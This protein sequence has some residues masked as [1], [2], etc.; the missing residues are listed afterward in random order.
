MIPPR[1]RFTPPP[2]KAVWNAYKEIWGVDF[3]TVFDVKGTQ[4]FVFNVINCVTREL[5]LSNVTT[6]PDLRWVLQQIRNCAMVT[7]GQLPEAIIHDNDKI[8]GKWFAHI[9]RNEFHV[10]PIATPY[11]SPWK[12]PHVERY[13]RSQKHEA[14]YRIPIASDSHARKLSSSYRGYYNDF[15]THQGIDGKIPSK[16]D[17]KRL[18]EAKNAISTYQKDTKVAGLIIHFSLAA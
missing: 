18:R 10:E 1:T 11:K 15:R 4:L 9:L 2:W 5:I 3:T 6:N 7:G 13:H 8:F 16:A 17:A 14:L 12:N